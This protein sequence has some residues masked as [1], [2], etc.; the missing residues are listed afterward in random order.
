MLTSQEIEIVESITETFKDSLIEI[1]DTQESDDSSM[2]DF[3]DNTLLLNYYTEK[4]YYKIFNVL[5]NK[6]DSRLLI[7]NTTSVVPST[8]SYRTIKETQIVGIKVLDKNFGHIFI[9]PETLED[10]LNEFFK[11][12]EFDFKD[13]PN[14][15]SKY[16]F[17]SDDSVSANSFATNHRLELLEKQ[18]DILLEVKGNLLIAKH[19]RVL[20]LKDFGCLLELIKEI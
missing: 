1:S 16:Y 3:A 11:Q 19:P 2:Y 17:L 13:F 4:F 14:F 18:K 15:S 8:K 9:R 6:I 7:V 10:K 12:S 20:N 5:N